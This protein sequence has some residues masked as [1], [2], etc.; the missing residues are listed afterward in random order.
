MISRECQVNSKNY[1]EHSR[2]IQN[3]I[4]RKKT[5]KLTNESNKPEQKKLKGQEKNIKKKKRIHINVR[6]SKNF[7]DPKDD[8]ERI[9]N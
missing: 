7:Q 8:N 4:V 5:N 9:M 6:T 2:R 1:P 3:E